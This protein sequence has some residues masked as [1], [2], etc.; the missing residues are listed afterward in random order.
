MTMAIIANL[1]K[2]MGLG[3]RKLAYSAVEDIVGPTGTIDTGLGTCE[4]A[5]IAGTGGTLVW[6][7]IDSI[8]AGS[9]YLKASTADAGMVGSALAVASE[10]TVQVSILAWGY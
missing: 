1:P 5:V 4:G 9:L 10:D 3:K 7:S 8:S 2:A 6:A